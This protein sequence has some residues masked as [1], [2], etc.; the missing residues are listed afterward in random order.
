MP[1]PTSRSP[2]LLTSFLSSFLSAPSAAGGASSNRARRSARVDRPLFCIVVSFLQ[3]ILPPRGAR[4]KSGSPY[5]YWMA[6]EEKEFLAAGRR[7]G[8]ARPHAPPAAGQGRPN[9]REHG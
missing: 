9:G 7:P 1:L 3:A 5:W 6:A 2:I 4:A 8:G